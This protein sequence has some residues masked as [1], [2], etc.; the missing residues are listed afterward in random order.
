MQRW[1]Q[2]ATRNWRARPIRTLGSVLAIALGTGAVVWVTCCYESVRQTVTRWSDNFIGHSDITVDSVAGKHHVFEQSIA[3]DLRGLPEV[4]RVTVRLVQRLRAAAVKRDQAVGDGAFLPMPQN[5]PE[6]DFHGVDPDNEF[7]FRSYTLTDGRMI[8]SGDRLAC[9]L[10][11]EYAA[12]AG[13]GVGDLLRLW[14]GD[15]DHPR[16]IE[17]VGVMERR[18]ITRFQKGF[19]LMA[20]PALQAVAGKDDL[21][22]SID[23]ILKHDAKASIAAARARIFA[24]AQR[25]EPAINVSSA[26]ARARQIEKAQ[27]QL[28]FVLALLSCVSMLTALFIILSTLSMGLVERIKQL[29]LLRCVGLT[30]GQ[31]AWL[32]LAEVM[33][34]GAVGVAAGIPIGLALTLVTRW[35]A[36]TYVGSFAI[37][38]TGIGLATG[39]GMVT[40]LLAAIVPAVGSAGV[41]PLEATRP[42]ARPARAW[43]LVTFGLLGAAALLIQ[44]GV[45]YELRRTPTFIKAATSAVVLLYAGYALLGPALIRL[46]GAPIAAAAAA[47]LRVRSRLMHDQIGHAV[48]RSAGICCGIM[49]GLSLIV[50]LVVFS[51]SVRAG[52][53]FPTQFPE[54]YIWSF[55]QLRDDAG[56]VA[57]GV[58]GVREQTAANAVN[59]IVDEK[60]ATIVAQVLHSVTWF[61]GCDPDTFFSL[62]R[63]EFLEG[64][65][66]EAIALLRKGGHIII[67]K[68][69]AITRNKRLGDTVRVVIGNRQRLFTVAGVI[70]SPALD[71]A[72]NYFQA[73]SETHVAAVGSVLGTNA[74]LKEVY[75]VE[76]R[77]L[78]LLNFDEPPPR[79]PD[80]PPPIGSAAA[81][82]LPA[83]VYDDRLPVERRWRRWQEEQVLAEVRRRIDAPAAFSGTVRELK[84]QIDAEITGMTRLLT[85]VP[86]V[87]LLV[88]AIGVANLMTA[89][90]YSR[91]RQLAVLRAVGATR[92][93]LLRMVVA[94]ALVLGVLGSGMGWL[95]GMHLALNT[96]S[97]TRTMWGLEA[98]IQVPW[99]YV[100]AAV[101]LTLGLSILAGIAPAR[102]AARTDVVSAMR[103]L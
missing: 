7:A 14:A 17:I 68:D 27:G 82:G 3:D 78:L 46:V 9:V 33:P 37:S 70:D 39:A 49:V 75:G 92:G 86:T 88:A 48:W 76:G 54:A 1:S 87:A 16:E 30:R 64:D 61:L 32:M 97:M 28:E 25:S 35:L 12:E 23:V 98:P 24:T 95:L 29:G 93:L 63:L 103:A 45:V 89:N 31:L 4:G 15:W 44:A 94:E 85:A 62:V 73:Q 50:G 21:I 80:W 100:G 10:D 84:D 22:N 53:Q 2:L 102:H 26:E 42:R 81:A 59:A 60:P 41:S 71:V 11:A 47:L 58:P 101:G 99:A 40:T 57:A 34:L 38:W 8:A 20:L 13:V 74:D 66:R 67:A 90:V 69:F 96:A 55:A 52:W 19:A 91:A 72:A 83:F 18:R 5:T 51:V 77:K 36:P 56:E 79:A 43:P 65:E 6:I